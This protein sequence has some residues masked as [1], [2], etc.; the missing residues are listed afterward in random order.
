VAVGAAIR[1]RGFALVLLLWLAAGLVPGLLTLSIEAPHWCRTLYT[2]PAAAVLATL[3]LAATARIGHRRQAPMAAALLLVVVAG[4]LWAFTTRIV[5]DHDVYNFFYP[6]VSKAAIIARERAASGFEVQASDE[7]ATEAYEEY[8]FWTIVGDQEDHVERVRLWESL[9]RYQCRPPVTM[10]I[11]LRDERLVAPLSALYPGSSLTVYR[12]PLQQPIARELELA[13]EAPPPGDDAN[14]V[15]I[16]HSGAYTVE[17]EGSA[18]LRIEGRA[19]RA[20]DRVVLPAGLWAV[21]CSPPSG[22][23]IVLSGPEPVIVERSL[24]AVAAPGHGLSATYIDND[25]SI[26]R[27]LDRLVF[28]NQRGHLQP[29]FEIEWRGRLAV[30]ETGTY[31]FQ[32]SADDFGELVIGGRTVLRYP[33]DEGYY[34]GVAS[35]DLEAG[36]HPLRIDFAKRKGGLTFDITWKPPWARDFDSIEPRYLVPAEG[37]QVLPPRN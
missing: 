6:R 12:D 10:L 19:L 35:L 32:V 15:L 30:P 25:G 21:E 13:C 29:Y 37:P 20:G 26:H 3:G 8:V 16:R 4:E 18:K 22:A 17:T 7:F 34:H 2:L 24:F 33:Y 14:A 1:R 11:A 5:D 23:G 9:P 36:E 31:E 27:Q 28:V